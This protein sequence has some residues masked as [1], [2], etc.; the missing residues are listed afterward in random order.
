MSKNRIIGIVLGAI[1]L[2]FLYM[3][4]QLPVSKYSTAIGPKVFP[5]IAS[6]GLLLCAIALFFKKDGIGAKEAKPFLDRAGWYRV[7]K[8]LILLA[9][10]P[11]IFLYLGFIIASLTLLFVMITFFD[12]NHEES[13]VKKVISSVSVTAILY[14]LFVYVINVR[15]PTGILIT[16]IFN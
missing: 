8:L 12:L 2:L 3:T 6:G 15:L 16:R 14:V 13:L 11:L 9:L 10:F 1:S 7:L 5:N 4:S